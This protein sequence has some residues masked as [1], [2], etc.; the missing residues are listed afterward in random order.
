MGYDTVTT[1]SLKIS[2]DNV[3]MASVVNDTVILELC[4]D[5]QDDVVAQCIIYLP[6]ID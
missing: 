4:A 6:I 3:L 1:A 2:S 5:D